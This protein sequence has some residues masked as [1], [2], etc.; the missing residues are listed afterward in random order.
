METW[1]E[2]VYGFRVLGPV[3]DDALA[4]LWEVAMLQHL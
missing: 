3:N 1:H 4:W 2:M